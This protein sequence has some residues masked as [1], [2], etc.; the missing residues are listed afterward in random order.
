MRVPEPTILMQHGCGLPL[1]FLPLTSSPRSTRRVAPQQPPGTLETNRCQIAKLYLRGWFA[2][3]FGSTVP[4]AQISEAMFTNESSSSVTRLTKMVKF[5]R[6]LRLMRML[7]LAKLAVIWDRIEAKIGSIFLIQC[8]SL[9]RVLGVVVAMCHW[10]ACLFWL[11]GLPTNLFTELMSDEGQAS[12]TAGPH[13]TTVWRKHDVD[14]EPWRWLD[15]SMSE[16]YIFCFYWTLGVMRT[17]PAEV[18]P[19]NLPERVFVL[20]F[21]FF[22]LSAFAICI[23]MITQAFFKISER[24]R[25]F[26]E[27]FA[28]V[29][30]HLRNSKVNEQVQER[31]KTYLKYLFNRRRIQA[32]EAN[33]MNQLPQDI[34]MQVVQCQVMH[35]VD[36][37][38]SVNRLHSSIR[39]KVC[40]I[41]HTCD[42]MAWETVV[43]SGQHAE[44]AWVLVAGRVQRVVID[45]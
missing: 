38:P 11:V 12:Y 30:L 15:R 33:L 23:S 29:R 27:E 32:K 14:S 42:I 28:A 39:R 24:R 36:K 18:T 13:W 19:V 25:A 44:S 40:E 26:H 9:L 34:K 3:D 45:E 35:Q 17:M 6:L 4:W 1:W 37:L 41:A 22:A 31:V 21:M 7:R 8:I 2:I 16:T 20:I 43:Q 10:S 5:I